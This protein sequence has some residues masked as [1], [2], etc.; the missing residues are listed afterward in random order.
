MAKLGESGNPVRFRVNNEQR[1]AEIVAICERNNWKFIGGIE[2]DESE[3]ISEVE[4]L[5]NPKAFSKKPKMKSSTNSTILKSKQDIGR[6]EPCPC[7]SGLK[8][9]KC[10]MNK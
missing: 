10:C 5:L 6:N 7:G 9:K 1:M 8:Y 4:Y 3:D 2:P